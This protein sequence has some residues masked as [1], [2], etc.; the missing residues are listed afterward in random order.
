MKDYNNNDSKKR[1]DKKELE[2]IVGGKGE[3]KKGFSGFGR[4]INDAGRCAE[5]ISRF[6]K[7]ECAKKVAV[8][9]NSG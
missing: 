8:L 6:H 4:L 5:H 9:A 7:Y 1:V 2:E 3:L